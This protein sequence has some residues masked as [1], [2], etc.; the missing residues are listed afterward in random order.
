MAGSERRAGPLRAAFGRLHWSRLLAGARNAPRFLRQV[1]VTFM[2]N[3]GLLLAGAVAYYSLLSILPLLIL[4]VLLLSHFLPEDQL[5]ST[6]SRYLD[7]V[8]SSQSVPLVEELTKFLRH[9]ELTSW[10][11]LATLLFSSS[12]AFAVL[13][14]SI[15][16]IFH[17][18]VRAHSRHWI[19]T[20]IIPYA[21]IL[22]LGAGLLLVTIA[23]SA[24]ETLG[25]HEIDILGHPQS[26]MRMSGAL[27]YVVG[28]AGEILLVSSI[29]LVMPVGRITWRQ[30]LVGGVTAGL[31]WE[32]TR[33]ALVWFFT[34]LSKINVLYGSF[35]TVIS[36]LLSF[37]LAATVLLLGAQVI[38]LREQNRQ[39]RARAR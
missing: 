14:R 35:A 33:H 7:L 3:K 31:L 6:L 37:E 22:V 25:A 8:A 30:A 15:A 34:T 39:A 29:Y 9:R 11:M 4:L 20:A 19:T 17:H 26:L 1:L 24:L 18:R 28:L 23:S 2:H 36:L 32:I 12:L 38:A 16:I 21:Y 27:L 5:L 13:E 10:A